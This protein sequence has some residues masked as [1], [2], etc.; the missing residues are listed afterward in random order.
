MMATK[1]QC[2]LRTLLL[3]V[4]EAA[5]LFLSYKNVPAVYGFSIAYSRKFFIGCLVGALI[6]SFVVALAKYTTTSW[7]FIQSILIPTVIA[8]WVGYVGLLRYAGSMTDAPQWPGMAMIYMF[9]A[10]MLL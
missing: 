5:V 7:K 10:S 8:S 9:P 2:N 3:I 6:G 1:L 4:L